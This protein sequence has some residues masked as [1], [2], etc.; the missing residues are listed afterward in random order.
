VGVS[1]GKVPYFTDVSTVQSLR[2]IINCLLAS[3]GGESVAPLTD[4][5]PHGNNKVCS[6][7][8]SRIGAT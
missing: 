3:T 5:L 6:G 7:R 2:D 1:K 4:P 8:R